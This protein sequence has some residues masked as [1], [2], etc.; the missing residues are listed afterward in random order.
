MRRY[1]VREVTVHQEVEVEAKCDGC[2]IA[3]DQTEFGSLVPVVIEINLDE[4]GGR[5]DELD[6]CDDCLMARAALFVAA[7]SR[8]PYVTGEEIAGEEPAE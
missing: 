7:G 3:E 4:E 6:F 1:E 8:A 2:G 5:R